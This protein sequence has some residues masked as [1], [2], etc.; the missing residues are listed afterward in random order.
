M[1][2]T[3]KRPIVVERFYDALDEKT[4]AELTAEQKA[5]VEKAIVAV[6]L[7]S[8]HRVDVRRSFPFFGRR[9]YYVFLFGRDRRRNQRQESALQRIIVSLLVVLALLFCLGSIFIALYLIKSALGID[10]FPHFH[11][12]LWDWFLHEERPRP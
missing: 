9:Y 6:T 12:G 3:A 4:T 1:N 5:A 8:R 2:D 7:S 10:I 11:L